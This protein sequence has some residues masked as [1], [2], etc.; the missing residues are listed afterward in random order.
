MR[1]RARPE[2][3]PKSPVERCEFWIR[4]DV[5]NV[6]EK[7][8]QGTP[9][10]DQNCH[11][12]A[13]EGTLRHPGAIH[14]TQELPM[15]GQ[16]GPRGGSQGLRDSKMNPTSYQNMPKRARGNSQA[17]RDS[18]INQTSNQNRQFHINA[19]THQCVNAKAGQVQGFF[20]GAHILYLLMA[21]KISLMVSQSVPK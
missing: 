10:L 19:S 17:L 20:F 1:H 8:P 5:G 18:K 6:I 11:K 21:Q 15:G 2:T 14:G 16:S 13:A 3:S 7:G 4:D 12:N 9:K